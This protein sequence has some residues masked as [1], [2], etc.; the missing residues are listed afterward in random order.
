MQKQQPN[1]LQRLDAMD[2]M[3]NGLRRVLLWMLFACAPWLA[4]AQ[5]RRIR[6]GF[7]NGVQVECDRCIGRAMVIGL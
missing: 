4:V 3:K 2:G 7:N 1:R 5:T 6:D